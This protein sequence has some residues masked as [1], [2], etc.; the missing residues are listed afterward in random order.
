MGPFGKH[1]VDLYRK[2]Y[3]VIPI[4][5]GKKRPAI[6]EWTTVELSESDVSEM[7][8]NGKAGCGIGIRTGRGLL[9]V[10]GFDA[11]IYTPEIAK[12]VREAFA[13]RFGAAPVRVGQAPKSLM[14]YC[15]VP[16][17]SKL[18][19]PKWNDP[20]APQG[21]KSGVEILGDGQQFVAFGVHEAT[22]KD[23]RWPHQSLLEVAASDLPFID[24][25]DVAQ[26]MREELPGLIP[27][28][29]QTEQVVTNEPTGNDAF[30]RVKPVLNLDDASIR[31]AVMVLD[32]D[33]EH[34][35]WVKVGMA[36]FH[37]YEGGTEG[38][39]LWDE[40][41]SQ[42]A[43]YDAELVDIKWRSFKEVGAKRTTTFASVLK[44]AKEKAPEQQLSWEDKLAGC[45]D[46]H[47]VSE[48][49]KKIKTDLALNDVGRA[50]LA[51]LVQKKLKDFGV[52]MAIKD[53][54][55]MVAVKRAVK[56]SGA[57]WTTGY[58]WCQFEDCFIHV[59]TNEAISKQSFNAR[60][61][62][63]VGPE[64]AD[65]FGNKPPASVV[66]LDEI[67]IPVVGRRMYL[68]TA[69]QFFHLNGLNYLNAYR[70]S[71]VPEASTT[72]SPAIDCVKGHITL[73]LGEE[74][75]NLFIQWLAHNVQKPGVKIRWSPMVK[76]IEGDGKTVLAEMMARVMGEP[77]V[78]M[79]SPKVLLT[80]FNGYAEGACLGV[81]EELK[82]AGHSRH[83]AANALKPNITNDNIPIHRKGVDE[84]N[85][86]N[87][88]NYLAF[89]NWADALPLTDAD[90]RWWVLFSRFQH[91]DELK[92]LS[93]GY[94]NALF[95]AIRN[96][97]ASLRGW[98]LGVDITGFNPNGR[99]PDSAAKEAMVASAKH[100]E[101]DWVSEAIEEGISGVS[102]YVIST[103]NL[104]S[105]METRGYEAPKGRS[106]AA[107]LIRLGFFK[108][109]RTVWWEG[110]NRRVWVRDLRISNDNEAIKALLEATHLVP[111]DF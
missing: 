61:N 95:D 10:Y 44:L 47:S 104:S 24:L 75:T 96:H 14:V 82:L 105:W 27:A 11:D 71:T 98:L 22:G 76:G 110:K 111:G 48:L 79:I 78:K 40:W 73:L 53:V 108:V 33:M 2:G 62:R 4:L 15:G 13:A 55:K 54:R 107:A 18:V 56:A 1:A 90:R 100:E 29:W 6:N 91:K 35:E 85:V 70:P 106:L 102:E 77:N 87:T 34:D 68:P 81:L 12:R 31:A 101:D 80:D 26:W 49:A 69:A 42:G 17:V 43:K 57:D 99:A 97:S 64:Y 41:S 25:E 103:D 37:Q 94:F 7:A 36:L 60:H 39:N 52:S 88:M 109:S 63:D 89:T 72:W 58:V 50:K 51:G 23:Y 16:G 5:H 3:D 19:S 65:D 28:E 46:E 84:Y 30:D 45:S 86:V 8:A 20:A 83:D 92:K 67:K 9:A 93:E 59:E 21:K 74:N 38:L 66:A 32:P